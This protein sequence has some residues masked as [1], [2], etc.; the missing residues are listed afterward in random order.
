MMTCPQCG[1]AVP[2][3]ATSCTRCGSP[4]TDPVAKTLAIATEDVAERDALLAQLRHELADGPDA[5]RRVR[6]VEA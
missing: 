6:L 4:V 1:T 3:G 2:A 5:V